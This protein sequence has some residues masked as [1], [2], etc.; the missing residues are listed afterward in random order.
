[1]MP[2]IQIRRA[3][4]DDLE[5]AWTLVQQYYASVADFADEMAQPSK[6]AFLQY[7][8]DTVAR[9][10]LVAQTSTEAVG[11][12]LLHE[13]DG[14]SYGMG[15]CLELGAIYVREPFR[16]RGVSKALWRE[17][18]AI[19]K[20][21]GLPVTSEVSVENELSREIIHGLLADCSDTEL[22]ERLRPKPDDTHRMQVTLWMPG[23]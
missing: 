13:I 19:A 16:R 15:R 11:F 22:A 10:V 20:P 12:C 14:T 8:S 9:H 6:P 23:E 4:S 3:S 5:S 18:V 17:A 2:D 7:W 1:M 21:R